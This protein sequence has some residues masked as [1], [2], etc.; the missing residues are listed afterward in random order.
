MNVAA[1]T[2]V[3]TQKSSVRTASP[4]VAPVECCGGTGGSEPFST[5]LAAQ[6]AALNCCD[7]RQLL[8]TDNEASLE[9]V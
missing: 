5:I 6:T 8:F 9:Y 1:N 2:N 3:R 4:T 7:L